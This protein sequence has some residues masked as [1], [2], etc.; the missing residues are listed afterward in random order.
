MSDWKPVGKDDEG[1]SLCKHGSPPGCIRC[2][3]K[4]SRGHIAFVD[5]GEYGLFEYF[6]AENGD[7]YKAKVGIDAFD[8]YGYRQ[9]RWE[10]PDRPLTRQVLGLPPKVTA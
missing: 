2:D 5:G 10:G 9:G 7:I 8:I 6:A 4:E 3:P 1:R